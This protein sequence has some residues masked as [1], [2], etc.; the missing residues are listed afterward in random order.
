MQ[1]LRCC[2]VSSILIFSQ[3][4]L[5]ISTSLYFSFIKPVLNNSNTLKNQ[6]IKPS[7]SLDLEVYREHSLSLISQ[8]PSQRNI[9]I[10]CSILFSQWIKSKKVNIA[11]LYAPDSE[12]RGQ[13]TK[14]TRSFILSDVAGASDSYQPVRYSFSGTLALWGPVG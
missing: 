11:L 8:F 10:H 12:Q 2:S 9:H 1:E 6:Q 4:L 5:C 3:I 13:G 14:F 7:L